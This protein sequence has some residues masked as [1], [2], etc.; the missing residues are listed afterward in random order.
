LVTLSQLIL[1]LIY[2]LALDTCNSLATL[3]NSDPP[4]LIFGLF[5]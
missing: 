3:E 4:C 1:S 5:S 2:M